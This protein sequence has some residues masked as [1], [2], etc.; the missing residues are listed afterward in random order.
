[1]VV[2]LDLHQDVNRLLMSTVFTGARLGE[3]ATGNKALDDRGVVLVR[4]QHTFAV[5]LVGVLDHAEQALFLSLAVDVPAG[6]E[7]L[8][9]A[10]FGVGLGEHHQFDVAGVAAQPLEAFHQ[11]VDLVI[12]QGQAQFDV[13][14]LQRGLAATEDVHPVEGLG[15]GVVEQLC[16]GLDAVQCLLGHAVVQ[17]RPDLLQVVAAQLAGNVIG[18]TPLKAVDHAQAAVVGDVRGLARPGRD[19]AEA[20]HYQ[21]QTAIGLF[22]RYR[23]AILEQPVQHRLILLGQLTGQVG[24]MHEFSVHSSH[25]GNLLLQTCQ[26]LVAPEIGKDWGS[27]QYMHVGIGLGIREV[28]KRKAHRIPQVARRSHLARRAA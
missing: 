9:P 22:H 25:A 17:Q 8:V 15:L 12:G 21:H 26:Q 7:D 18:D 24:K 11:V 1:M 5:H 28:E 6:V 2:G 14:L 16:G 3:E 27:T 13:G 23:G 10:V 4:G 19:G 20:R